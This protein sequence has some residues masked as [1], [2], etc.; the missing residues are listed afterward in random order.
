MVA[1]DGGVVAGGVEELLE[2]VFIDVYVGVPRDKGP[3]PIRNRWADGGPSL[4]DTCATA[5]EAF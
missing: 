2:S 4:G 5:E 3:W 1:S